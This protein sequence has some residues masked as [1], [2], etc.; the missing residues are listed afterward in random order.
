MGFVK[1]CLCI[2]ISTCI[3]VKDTGQVFTLC[4][5]CKKLQEKKV[6]CLGSGEMSTIMSEDGTRNK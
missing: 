5:K 1:S 6:I 2:S 4:D 3:V